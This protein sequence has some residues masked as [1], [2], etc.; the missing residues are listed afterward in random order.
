MDMNMI[1]SFPKKVPPQKQQKQPGILSLMNPQPVHEDPGY[2]PSGK[3]QGKVALITGGDSG[4]GRSVAIA[5]ALEGGDVAVGYLDEKEDAE[6]TKRIIEGKGKRCLLISGDIGDEIFCREMIEKTIK[7]FGKLDILVN[8]AGEQHPQK[9]I[10]DITRYQLERTFKTNIFSMFYLS[11][12]AMPHLKPGSSIINTSSVVAYHGDEL[13]LDYSSSK[14]AVVAF[15]R[16]LA[17]NLASK[18]I[19]VNAVAPGPIWTPL[20]PASFNQ[21]EVGN[22]G[23]N[24]PIGR[25]GQPVELAG[26]YVF[27]ASND[28]SFITGQTIHVNGGEMVN[29]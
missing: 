14:G 5:F 23:S 24:A 22:F 20:I 2:M 8:N 9:S 7:E 17:L 11:K 28:A 15:T 1:N 4:I 29:G 3:L 19:R 10:E 16:S 21:A 27:L 13:L 6:E 26:A 18:G 12:A 25:P